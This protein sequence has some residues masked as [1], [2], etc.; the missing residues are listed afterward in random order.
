VEKI[1]YL[2]FAG[3]D[4]ALDGHRDRMLDQCAP[5]LL[6][7]GA[8]GLTLHAR[9]S[10]AK[11]ASPS[12]GMTGRPPFSALI[13]LWLDD[14]D[15]RAAYERILLDHSP[16]IAGYLVTESLYTDYGDNRHG[17]A[18]DWPDGDR[19]PGVVTVTVLEKPERYVY[20]PWLAHWYGT[21]SPV[22]EAMQPRMRYVR[23]TVACALTPASPPYA[24]IV[25]EAWPSA[26]H[27]T[28]PYL[29]YGASDLDQ[30]ADH[31]GTML[32]SVTGFLDLPR[33]QS[34]P[35]S[36]YLLRTPTFGGR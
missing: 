2:G 25:E 32:R 10:D 8:L 15:E 14:A 4:A 11:V 31:M 9:D 21:Q 18:R 23:N 34:V 36:E 33:I 29:F 26:R 17:R 27:I 22:S 6:A 12:P 5:A 3:T 24:G 28:D 1:I 19:S 7:E 20:E 35:M 30:L 13:S 16:R